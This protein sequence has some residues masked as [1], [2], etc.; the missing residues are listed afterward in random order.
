MMS[1]QQSVRNMGIA[2]FF[3][4]APKQSKTAV[5]LNSHKHSQVNCVP[6][7]FQPNGVLAGTAAAGEM[8]PPASTR[9]SAW[10]KRVQGQTSSVNM[11]STSIVLLSSY[12]TIIPC[13]SGSVLARLAPYD[14]NTHEVFLFSWRESGIAHPGSTATR[15][16]RSA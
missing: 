3:F 2:C 5:C 12:S 16:Y 15:S 11:H 14:T 9:I 4:P 7:T 1:A 13:H 6:N 10:L 8:A